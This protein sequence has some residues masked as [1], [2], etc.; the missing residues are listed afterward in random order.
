M[1]NL[2]KDKEPSQIACIPVIIFS[3]SILP[4]MYFNVNFGLWICIFTCA[5]GIVAIILTILGK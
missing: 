3:L 2:L 4:A 5:S 1:I